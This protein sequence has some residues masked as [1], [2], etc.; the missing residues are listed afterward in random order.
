MGDPMTDLNAVLAHYDLG[1]LQGIEKDQ[2]GTVNTSFFIDTVK[3]ARR[4]RYFLRRYRPG[5][6]RHELRFEHALI[7]HLSARGGC[8]VARV[9]MTRQ[10]ETVLEHNGA[11]YAV[12][13]YLPGEDR[14]TWVDPRCTSHELRAAGRLLAQFHSDVAGF[15]APGHREEPRILRL[16]N[17]MAREWERAC[18]RPATDAYM[19]YVLKHA[20]EV[21]RSVAATSDI[22]RRSAGGLPKVI[23]HSDYHPGNLKFEGAEISGLV[24]FDWAKVDVRA[25]DVALAVWYFCASWEGAAD[26][27]LR[28]GEVRTFLGGYQDRLREPAAISP[29]SATELAALPDLINAGS[30]YILYWGLRD[31]ASKPVDPEEYLVYLRHSVQT[32]RW[33]SRP[34]NRRRLSAILHSLR[35][36]EKRRAG[37]A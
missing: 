14:Y 11:F 9:H 21:R 31:Y 36:P 18:R 22:L 15:R 29:L 12:F 25:F 3:D 4:C 2:R 27:R 30:L 8:P 19:R 32:S 26:G 17:V 6:Q 16:F 37:R 33:L 35:P 1:V 28:L 7:N 34:A 10:G 20:D 13:D 23:V 24:D 5:I